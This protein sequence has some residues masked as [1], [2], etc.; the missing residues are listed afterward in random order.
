MDT[1]AIRAEVDRLDREIKGLE[2]ER[3]AVDA[4]LLPKQREREH[5][6]SIL[7]LR[8][9]TH[10]EVEAADAT[11]PVVSLAEVKNTRKEYGDTARA[12]RALLLGRNGKGVSMK[13]LSAE[14]NRLGAG[15]QAP[16]QW[17]NRQRN[18]RPPTIE[19]RGDVLFATEHLTSN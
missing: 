17:V 13:E 3:A 9:S 1:L 11:R 7:V 2:A 15:K 10:A 12:F 16:Y 5:W 19:K 4:R 14:A 6:K 8:Q 18:R